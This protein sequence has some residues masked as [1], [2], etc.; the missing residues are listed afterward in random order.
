MINSNPFYDSEAYRESIQILSDEEIF[1]MIA[2]GMPEM[3]R[4]MKPGDKGL[5]EKHDRTL[6]TDGRL[7]TL[8]YI[9]GEKATEN[10]VAPAK[11]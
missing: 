4:S 9:S 2:E 8:T 10:S 6:Q 5:L 11:P 3:L 1:A 7:F